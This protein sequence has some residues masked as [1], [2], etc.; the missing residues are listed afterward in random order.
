[1]L[2]DYCHWQWIYIWIQQGNNVVFPF[3]FLSLTKFKITSDYYYYRCMLND[4][5]FMWWWWWWVLC[6]PSVIKIAE[7]QRG[8][9][10]NEHVVEMAVPFQ[11]HHSLVMNSRNATASNPIGKNDYHHCC[12]SSHLETDSDRRGLQWHRWYLSF[13]G[14]RST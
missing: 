3:F 1:M 10:S 7:D 4:Y 13:R 5:W 6:C 12:S 2:L 9:R 8:Q 14:C 11:S